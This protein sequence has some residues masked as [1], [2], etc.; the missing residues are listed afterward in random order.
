MEN[1]S[2]KSLIEK[3]G[4]K[5]GSRVSVL[6]ITAEEDFWTQLK[7]RTSDI[8]E[9]HVVKDSDFIFFLAKHKED[10][11]KLKSFQGY[12]KRNGAIWVVW[13]KGRQ[14]IKEGD[15]IEAGKRSGLVDTKVVCFSETHSALK[16]VI[17]VARR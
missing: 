1:K 4:V 17:P 5:E 10:L 12:I 6:G 14:E 7:T 2:S 3:L 8:V 16:L 13:P 15:I 9:T 11:Q